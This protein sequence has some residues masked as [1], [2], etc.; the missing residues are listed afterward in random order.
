[1]ECYAWTEDDA[2]DHREDPN[3]SG[4]DESFSKSSEKLP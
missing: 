4:E 3:D 2:R 1:R